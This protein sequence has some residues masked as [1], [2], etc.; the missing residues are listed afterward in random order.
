MNREEFEKI[1]IKENDVIY[2]TTGDKVYSKLPFHFIYSNCP[3]N[4]SELEN[5]EIVVGMD[6]ELDTTY[7][8]GKYAVFSAS[9]GD[10]GRDGYG[11][12]IPFSWIVRARKITEK[13]MP[14]IEIYFSQCREYLSG[15]IEV[16]NNIKVI[17][18]ADI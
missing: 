11:D 9:W 17:G 13:R 1:K 14:I 18:K 12:A 6:R 10:G 2:I 16:E 5:A 15:N 8:I 3:G 4:F 7:L